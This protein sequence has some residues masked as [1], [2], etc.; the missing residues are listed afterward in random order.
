M[1]NRNKIFLIVFGALLSGFLLGWWAFGGDAAAPTLHGHDAAPTA[2]NTTWT[3]SMHPQI[4]QG[5]P[6]LC[7]ICGMDLIPLTAEADDTDPTALKMT[8]TAVKL[9]NI[10]TTVVEIQSPVRELRLNGKVQTD[11]RKV[12]AQASHLAGRIEALRVN[13][14]GEA[15]KK[16]QVLAIIYSPDLVTAQEELLAARKMQESQPALFQ[17]AKEKLKNWKLTDEQVDA[18]LESGK[19]QE[20]FPILADVSGVVVNK[21]VNLGDYVSRG[22]AIFEIADLSAVWLQF[23]VYESD[24]P[25]VRVGSKVKYS[26]QALPGK[27]RTGVVSFIDPFIDPQT[28]VARAR[29]AASN[30]GRQ[31]KPEMF[32]TGN[33][34]SKLAQQADEI[35][36]PKAAVM[37]TGE[38]SVVYVKAEVSGK[39]AF[40]LREV[41]LGPSLGD[42]YVIE[43]GLSVGEEIVSQGTF[44]VDAAA[45]LAGKPSMMNPTTGQAATGHDHGAMK[46]D[47]QTPVENAASPAVDPRFQQQLG[48][49]VSGYLAVNEALIAS[50]PVAAKK[51]AQI[52]EEALK[53]TDM[54]LL[55]G[56]AHTQWMSWLSN[57]QAALETLQAATDLAAQRTAYMKLGEGL[58]AS[59]KAFGA[60][61]PTLYYQYC[62]MAVGNQGAYW[63]SKDKEIYNPYFGE[64][65]L[66]CGE[67]KE[68]LFLGKQ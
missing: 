19:P 59:L 43:S 53:K 23:D 57:M 12:F 8:P 30:P 65:M 52:M 26:V 60:D 61:G 67:N 45:Q 25:W 51:Q 20:H 18:V 32:A 37:W 3:C 40:S 14:T 13:F 24:L 15:V 56:S 66:K 22:M 49:V 50:D 1:N 47:Q 17:A 4:R 54:N 2:V 64:S 55:K 10:Q 9:A 68:T 46:M 38:R 31:L 62:P 16:G 35:T 28:R 11:E 7:P 6:G 27:T 39:I 5:E 33:I 21:K 44:T 36:V 34:E 42:A 48:T 41:Q 63:L 58:Y 29:V